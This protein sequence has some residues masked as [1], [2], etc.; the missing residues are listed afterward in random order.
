[1]NFFAQ[2]ISLLPGMHWL[3]LPEEVEV[4][5]HMMNQQLDMRNEAENLITFENNFS[6]RKV[7]VTFPRPLQSY[8]THD[9]LVE[10]Y[11][12]AVPL[13]AFLRN[14]GGPYDD[15]VATMGLDAFLVRPC[16]DFNNSL[17]EFSLEHATTRQF[18]SL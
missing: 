11:E 18:C 1:M 4:F 12:N 8:S 7:P 2:A 13:E 14:G 15:E 6:T 3:S 17:I 16:C 5:G 10:E 9:I